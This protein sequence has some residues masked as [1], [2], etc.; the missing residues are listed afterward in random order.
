MQVLNALLD[1][2]CLAPNLYDIGYGS[3]QL[4]CCGGMVVLPA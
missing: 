3:R 2:N 1:D 4:R